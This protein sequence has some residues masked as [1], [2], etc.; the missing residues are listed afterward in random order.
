MQIKRGYEDY[1]RTILEISESS[2]SVKN[3][4]IAK[5]LKISK[6]SVSEML[7]KLKKDGLIEFQPY[8]KINLT[9][10]GRAR[11]ERVSEKFKIIR[12]F[13]HKLGHKTPHDEAHKLEHALSPGMITRISELLYGKS[14]QNTP[15]PYIS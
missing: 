15:P 9:R 1:L 8:S 3:I 10:K 2:S 13:A 7:R 14:K 4:D 5:S 12:H 11:A 6:P